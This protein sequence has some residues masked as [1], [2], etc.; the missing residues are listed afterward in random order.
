VSTGK[1]S[2]FFS[3]AASDQLKEFTHS[4]EEALG[5]HN[6]LHWFPQAPCKGSGF[7]FI[8][9]LFTQESHKVDEIRAQKHKQLTMW[10]DPFEVSFRIGEDGSIC[11]LYESTPPVPTYANT[12]DMISCKEEMR[13]ERS[14]PSKSFNVMTVSG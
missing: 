1:K 5:E 10:V 7:V 3:T 2:T 9:I 6:Q 11:V 12:T 14:S 13:F 4:L 8:Y